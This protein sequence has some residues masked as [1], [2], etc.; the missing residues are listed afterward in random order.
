MKAVGFYK[1]LPTSH[2]E[3]L[4]DVEIETPV[5][6]GRDLL[7]RIHAV[8]VNPFDCEMRAPRDGGEVTPRVLGWDAAGVVEAAGPLC[9]L[10]EPGDAVFYAGDPSRPGCNSEFHLVDER[11]VG[12]KPEQL[13]YTS[14][15]ALPLS[16]ITAYEALFERLGIARNG[17]DSGKSILIIGA[18]GGVG[19]MAV[20]LA[21]KVAH[22]RV[23]ATASRPLSQHWCLRLGAEAVIDHFG[24]L[25][26]QLK[27]ED[28]E[29]VDYILCLND[30]DRYFD[31]MA[32]L[33]QPQGRICAVAETRRPH[34]LN[35]LNRKSAAFVWESPFTRSLYRTPDV[36]VQH[37]LLDAI[38]DLVDLGTIDTTVTD[39]LGPL[40]ADNLRKAHAEIESGRT[41]GK[42]VLEGYH[43]VSEIRRM[44]RRGIGTTE[45]DH[46][47]LFASGC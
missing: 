46:P 7:V 12:R 4:V 6:T 1:Y 33:I 43:R 47:R 45:S 22:L 19:S 8:A 40:N 31:T 15:A 36:S 17:A 32:T 23:I 38:A 16:S 28:L 34:D 11:L 27:R 44:R 10:F 35:L 42:L 24:D 25:R 37:R 26:A 30:T 13:G 18:A 2:P 20:Q 21:S 41:V 5:A 9:T 39:V 29:A 3:S 14:A